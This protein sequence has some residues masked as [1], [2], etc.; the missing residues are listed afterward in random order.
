MN[1]RSLVYSFSVLVAFSGLSAFAA[2]PVIG[3]AVSEGQLSVNN[4][5]IDGN[6]NLMNGSV[7]RT[8]DSPSRLH[9]KNGAQILLDRNT[10]A[11]VLGDRI[12]LER[13]VT[14]IS[15]RN[16]TSYDLEALGFRV[17]TA[18]TGQARV[19][20]QNDRV[21]VAALNGPVQV[22]GQDGIVLASVS[23]GRTLSFEPAAASGKSEMTGR[24]QKQG[25][26]FILPDEVSGLKVELNGKG[27][28]REV[29]QRVRVEGTAL[30]SDDKQ[31]QVIQVARV[32]R[33][34]AFPEPTPGPS[35]TPSPV[36]QA[37]GS[38]GG[39]SNGAKVAIVLGV[40]G[41]VGITAGVLATQSR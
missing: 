15:S 16:N 28:D 23:A 14:Q 30:S 24:I 17:A 41:A 32:N 3:M 10:Q 18:T 4:S 5:L 13:G 40:V 8:A 37:G 20:M 11:K 25:E 6:A 31:S 26:K 9:M 36:P 34:A 21:V 2:S 33:L 38:A 35:P 19:E 7:V 27:L 22:S 12:V 39:L 1:R 29:G